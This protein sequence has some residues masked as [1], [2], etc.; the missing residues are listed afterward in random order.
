MGQSPLSSPLFPGLAAGIPSSAGRMLLRP[1]CSYSLP[2]LALLDIFS[3]Q[4]TPVF[5]MQIYVT[6]ICTGVSGT[7]RFSPG[8]DPNDD[9]G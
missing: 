1:A 2:L 3:N 7:C 6:H 9:A 5:S 8:I 4:G